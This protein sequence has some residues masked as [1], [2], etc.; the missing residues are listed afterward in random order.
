MNLLQAAMSQ[1]EREQEERILRVRLAELPKDSDERDSKSRW[2]S[3]DE[4]E[5]LGL[6]DRRVPQKRNQ[7]LNLFRTNDTIDVDVV[8]EALG[9]TRG[10]AEKQL[11]RAFK[12]G[13][14]QRVS[15]GVYRRKA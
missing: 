13:L 1:R 9:L 8:V 7:I 3:E 12:L 14:I 10:A 5:A 11:S 6:V 15:F 4:R 2:L